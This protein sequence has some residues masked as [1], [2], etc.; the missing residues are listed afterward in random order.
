[1]FKRYAKVIKQF[2]GF[3]A[4][5]KSL[6]FWMMF[7]LLLWNI[8]YMCFP[9]LASLII[10]A[11]TLQDFEK[12]A[13]LTGAFA[14]CGL[15]Y[16]LAGH[17]Y[18][19]AYTNNSLY[20][21]DKLQELLLRKIVTFDEAFSQDIPPARVVNTAFSDI[22]R[23]V[24]IPDLSMS[25]LIEII[26][27]AVSGVIL[28]RANIYVGL[29]AL[30]LCVLAFLALSKNTKKRDYYLEKQRRQQDSIAGVMGQALDGNKEINAF[31]ME[32]DMSEYLDGYKKLWKRDYFKRRHYNDNIFVLVPMIFGLGK[33][34]IYGVLIYL[35]LQ[36]SYELSALVLVIG[37]FER[38][39]DSFGW[40]SDLMTEL[41]KNAERVGRFVEIF[42]YRTKNMQRFGK[43]KLD[44]IAGEIEF[45][46]V[47]LKYE[48]QESMKNMSFKIAPKSF[49]AIVGKSGSGKSTIF[50]VLLRLYKISQ[51]EVLLDGQ[52]IY[53]YSEDVYARNV[54][55]VTQRP[56][57][58]DMTIR[59]N[60]SLVD[61]NRER[62]I[63]ACKKA[64]VHDFV[65]NLPDKYNTMMLRDAENISTGHK[66]LL[67]LARTLLSGSEV[68]LFDE[69]TSSLE[70]DASQRV[71]KVIKRLKKDH[72]VLMVTHKPE[73]MRVA[74]DIMVIDNGKLVGRGSHRELMAKN[75]YYRV[76]QGK[77]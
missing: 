1:M 14:V 48:T 24:R 18:Y 36:G 54:S 56:F 2:F 38:M 75:K 34:V 10:D 43:N 33:V 55:I 58:F 52:N 31:N 9:F 66:Q 53:D 65:M 50:R 6:V 63:E 73:L 11:L 37:Y 35:I 45:K 16:V 47:S 67:A 40:S 49:T 15:L 42:G 12:A 7:F 60:L 44:D 77:E 4:T 8:F 62:Q 25:L 20:I 61:P 32:D 71:M 64:G 70:A 19:K 72:T 59:E 68:L 13:M 3:G 69:V 41:S 51:G 30:G 21:H 28:L 29:L 5:K 27:M 17:C 46:K 57:M 23:V 76:L 39:E 74:D 22:Q 26:S